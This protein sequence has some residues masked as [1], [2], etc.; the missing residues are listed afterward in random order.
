[1]NTLAHLAAIV[2][3]G[4]LSV[5]LYSDLGEPLLG[6]AA[7]GVLLVLLVWVWWAVREDTESGS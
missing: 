6:F 5:W 1:M 2:A 7:I 3:L 4:R